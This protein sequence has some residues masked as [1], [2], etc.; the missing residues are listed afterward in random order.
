MLSRCY[1]D[2]ATGFSNYGGRGIGVCDRWRGSFESFLTDMGECPSPGHSIE[3][4][5]NDAGYSPANCIWADRKT[6]GNNRRSNRR[7]TALGES[8]T[9]SEWAERLGVKASVVRSRLNRGWD[10]DLAVSVARADRGVYGPKKVKT[11]VVD[12]VSKTLLQWAHTV[13]I[14]VTSLRLR[15]RSGWSDRQ[16][17]TTPKGGERVR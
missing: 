6:Q 16:A 17:V 11:I 5:D 7:V 15:L 9:L 10:A 1:N 13:G 3:R 14:S 8:K 12:G 2:T 4:V